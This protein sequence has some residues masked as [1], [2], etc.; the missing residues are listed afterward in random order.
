MRAITIILGIII[1]LAA[2]YL[3]G[4]T[5]TKPVFN[6]TLPIIPDGVE[7]QVDSIDSGKMVRPWNEANI[8]LANDSIKSQIEFVLTLVRNKKN[9]PV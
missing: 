3:V 2:I 9:L 4:P 1:L 7:H 6:T 5:I 8:I